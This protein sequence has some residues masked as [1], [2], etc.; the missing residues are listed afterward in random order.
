MPWIHAARRAAA[1][2]VRVKG[3][4]LTL[5]LLPGRF[6]VCRLDPGAPLP[7]WVLHEDAGVWSMTRT[8]DELSIVCDEDAVPPS[9]SRVEPGWRAL[10]VAGPIPFDETG[11]LA[12]LATPLAEAGIPLFALS[13][14]DTDVVLVRAA[15]L[16]RALAALRR[17]HQVE[18][19]AG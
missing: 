12:G 16:E 11:V 4:A 13:T 5:R 3:R 1:P 2:G 15:D 9:V 14:Y 7:A 6:A 18:A 17:H 19:D 10:Q 8:P